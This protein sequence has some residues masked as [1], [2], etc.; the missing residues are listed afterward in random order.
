MT[1]IFAY[2]DDFFNDSDNYISYSVS[3]ILVNELMCF[4]DLYNILLSKLDSYIDIWLCL[5]PI[6]SLKKW[7][8][9][10]RNEVDYQV[11]D[12][13]KSIEQFLR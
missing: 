1:K 3:E 11:T 10:R 2:Y 5:C 8:F 9:D 6:K 13:T 7:F 12:F 4:Q